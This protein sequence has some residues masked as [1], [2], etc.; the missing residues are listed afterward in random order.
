MT[1]R[2]N[3]SISK[4]LLEQ[5]DAAAKAANISRSGMLSQAVLKYLHGKALYRRK[6]ASDEIGRIR[7]TYGPWDGTAE[8][9]KGRDQH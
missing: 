7:E 2:I 8:V 5:V 9:I 3:I 4:E 1:V 6:K